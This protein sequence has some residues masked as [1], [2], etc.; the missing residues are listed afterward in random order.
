[1]P[2]KKTLGGFTIPPPPANERRATGFTALQIA[3]FVHRNRLECEASTDGAPD[4][5]Y[6]EGFAAALLHVERYVML[7]FGERVREVQQHLVAG[8]PEE[9]PVAGAN[10]D[11][12][13][14]YA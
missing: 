6:A 1:M 11:G 12:G 10:T 9:E 3:E 14:G 8:M 5:T 7:H 13:G 2:D 4:G